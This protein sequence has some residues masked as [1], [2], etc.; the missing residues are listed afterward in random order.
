MNI[1]QR[2]EQYVPPPKINDLVRIPIDIEIYDDGEGINP[3]SQK[4]YSY[5]YISVNDRE[6]RVPESVISQLKEQLKENPEMAAFKVTK[7]GEGILSKY[8]VV[9]ILK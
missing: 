8:T 2:A 9:P 1:R 3:E 7:K 6:I 4:G 5:S